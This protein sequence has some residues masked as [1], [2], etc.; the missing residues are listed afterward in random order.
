[1]NS[2]TDKRKSLGLF[3][4][5]HP[6]KKEKKNNEQQQQEEDEQRCGISS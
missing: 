5:D 3:D 1:M 4:K 2:K 6:D